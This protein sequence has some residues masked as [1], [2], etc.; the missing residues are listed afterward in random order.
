MGNDARRRQFRPVTDGPRSRLN[1]PVLVRQFRPVTDGRTDDDL[2]LS[3]PVLVRELL[4][5]ATDDA[6]NC[7]LIASSLLCVVHRAPLCP[8]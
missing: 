3:V 7:R 2:D 1:V 6:Q 8:V 5:G 4:I